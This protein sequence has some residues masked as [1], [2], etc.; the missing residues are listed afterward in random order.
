MLRI[1]LLFSLFLAS[2][3]GK[4]QVLENYDTNWAIREHYFLME[5]TLQYEVMLP[6]TSFPESFFK[7]QIPSDHSIF[8]EDVLWKIISEDTTFYIPIK[9]MK[10]EFN[11]DSIQISIIGQ[12]QKNEDFLIKISKEVST[13][14]E[15]PKETV[16]PVFPVANRIPIHLIKDFF[17]V[18]TLIF[19]FF[20][21][22]YRSAFP[23]LLGVLLKPSA[24]LNGEDFSEAG[25]LQKFISIDILFF[26]F[27][28]GL[29]AGQSLFTGVLVYRMD[30]ITNWI[31]WNFASFIIIWLIFSFIV[32]LGLM[33]KFGFIK[34]LGYFFNL[35]KSDFAHF[36]YVIRLIVFG[37][38]F[39]NLCTIFLLG[40]D[41]SSLEPVF[42]SLVSGFFWFYLL[43]ISLLFL[44]IMNR[45]SFK[46][47]H[48]FTY[49]CL[50]ELVPFFILYK[51]IMVLGK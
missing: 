23:F 13:S 41:F 10:D 40:Y 49:L 12:E 38:A 51:G 26:L 1:I 37:I 28:L 11:K 34:L 46:K 17:Y 36:F 3:L 29:M 24:V 35:G 21:A 39:I 22:A 4:A 18:T 50:V 20:L 42:K 43:G 16:I 2:F 9:S 8:I 48:L 44:I 45:L 31:G 6:L 14:R 5:K 25:T 32:F 33:L 7:F 30:L 47:Y 15:S 27:I 19:L